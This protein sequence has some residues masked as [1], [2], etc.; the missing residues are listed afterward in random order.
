MTVPSF[1]GY[2]T[3]VVRRKT[4]QMQRP[5]K[6]VL[7]LLAL[8]LFSCAHQQPL[9]E[10]TGESGSS[11]KTDSS[12][13]P[14][15]LTLIAAGDN[16]YHSVMIRSG[17][18]GNYEAAY[19]QIRPLTE[20]ADIAFINQETLLAGGSFGLSGYPK[21]NSPLKLGQ[22][23]AAA[24]FNVVNHATNHI[25]DKGEKAVIATLDFW[26]TVPGI[27]VLGIHRSEEALNRPA[28]V[29]KNNITVGFLSFTYGTN[30]IPVPADKPWLVSLINREAM[31][32]EIEAL[33]PL[34]DFLVVSMHWGEEYRSDY[35]KTQEDLAVFLAEHRVDLVI[36]HHPHLIQPVKYIRRPDNRFMLCFY[37]LGNLISAQ[38]QNPALLGALAYVKIEKQNGPLKGAGMETG[39]ES[40][41][42]FADAGAI[43]VV[44]HYEKNY[45]DF[46]IYPL[47]GYTEELA[48]KHRR[49]ELK[50]ELT[51]DYLKGLAA[52]V[53]GEM[54]ILR[55]PLN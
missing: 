54:E 14:D 23:V 4:Q 53:L 40:N 11:C 24:G 47:Y 41:I 7:L 10:R 29:R 45:T 52:R 44:T 3:F 16:L 17:E 46:K 28:L 39:A 15:Y 5:Y 8:G 27:T 30:D 37:S 21:F 25:M 32:K 38:S 35:S 13:Q 12:M 6:I 9:S 33:R 48:A 20:K 49:N 18:D 34:C 26:D 22:A 19:S 42:T 2:G 36:G 51:V 31:A 43:P 1:S 50:K 55:N